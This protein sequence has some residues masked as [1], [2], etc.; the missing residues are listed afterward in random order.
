MA[1]KKQKR[2]AALA[3]REAYM[4][5]VRADGLKALEED[6]KRRE[7]QRKKIVEEAMIINDR[8]R[9][10]LKSAFVMGS[11]ATK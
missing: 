7:E 8:H 5:E 9:D 4:A 2:A 1:T 6:R 11:R 10:I 3:K